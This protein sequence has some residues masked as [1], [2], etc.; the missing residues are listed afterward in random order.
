MSRSLYICYF[1]V[2]EPLVQTQVIPYLRELVK[3]GHEITLLTFEPTALDAEG[4][5]AG[6]AACGPD[7]DWHWLKYHKRLSVLATA[8]D[9][10][11]GVR[12]I[13]TFI[14]REKPDIL[15]AR[16]H[17]PA[18][19]AALARKFSRRKPKLLFDIRGFMPEEYTDAGLW[20]KGGWLYRSAKSVERWLMRESDGFVVL[21]E[22]AREIL[23]PESANTGYDKHDRPV[24]VIPCCVDF[25]RRF[26]PD[27]NGGGSAVR[28]KLN[29]GDRP[30]ITHV[31][32]LTGLYLTEQIADLLKVARQIDPSTFALFLTQTPP[33]EIVSMLKSRGYS[34]TDFFVSRVGPGDVRSY[35]EASDVALSFVRAGYATASRSPTKIPE[36]LASGLPII[37][38][39]GVGDVDELIGRNSVGVAIGS[40]D[41]ESYASALA[42]VRGLGDVSARC[43]ETAL[44]EFD[45]EKVGGV[46]YRRLYSRILGLNEREDATRAVN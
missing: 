34:E 10:L 17:V 32:A 13:R 7:I 38:N 22:K 15:H 26:S 39:S 24:E 42:Q 18:L 12:F 30:V 6:K 11:Q 4:V 37:A 9:V 28:R 16:V 3:G 43:R 33:D 21:T 45:L 44:R 2:R 5:D 36:Y 31:G 23:F 19:M 35:L 41:D 40:F 25:D 29:I 8:W 27:L 20:P 14:A 46:R 1:G